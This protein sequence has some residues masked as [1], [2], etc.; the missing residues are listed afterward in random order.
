MGHTYC[1]LLVHVVF[2]TKERQ[3]F[4]HEPLRPRLHAYMGGIAR[5]EFGRALCIGGTE[6]HVHGLLSLNTS[7]SAAEAM[8]K[9]KSLSSGWVHDTFPE[10][11]AFAW[12]EGYGVFSVSRSNAGQVTRYIENQMQHHKRQTFQEEFIALLERHEIEYDPEKIWL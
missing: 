3:R 1:S 12:Q 10:S 7:V 6:D 2:S 4:I 11:A 8:R 5:A 9:W